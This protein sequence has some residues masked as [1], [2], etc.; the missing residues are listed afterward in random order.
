MVQ[1]PR[2]GLNVYARPVRCAHCSILGQPLSGLETTVSRTLVGSIALRDGDSPAILKD[3]VSHDKKI[4]HSSSSARH[5]RFPGDGLCA[6]TP[7]APG[8]DRTAA[9]G[10]NAARS[11]VY[12]ARHYQVL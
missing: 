6:A 11:Y 7:A 9:I 5:W 1:V 12:P 2:H 8:Y 3:E 4:N 10:G